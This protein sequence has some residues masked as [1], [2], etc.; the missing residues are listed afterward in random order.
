[1]KK[2]FLMSAFAL[3]GVAANA[4]TGTV[5]STSCGKQVM[6]CSIYEFETSFDFVD[7][8]D[9]LNETYCGTRGGYTISPR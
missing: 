3:M 6:T 1:M 8:L 2:L 5:V 7:Y 4:S 9:D